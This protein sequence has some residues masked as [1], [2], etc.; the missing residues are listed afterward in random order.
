MPGGGW[1]RVYSALLTRCEDGTLAIAAVDLHTVRIACPKPAI[2]EQ[3]EALL[4]QI[5]AA[6]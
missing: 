6:R 3:R 1:T 4:G 2:R 5:S